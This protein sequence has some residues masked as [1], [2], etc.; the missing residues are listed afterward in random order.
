MRQTFINTGLLRIL[1]IGLVLV[2]LLLCSSLQV[3]AQCSNTC[4]P[5]LI[6]NPDFETTTVDCVGGSSGSEMFT[7]YSQVDGWFGTDQVFNDASHPDY[8]NSDCDGET[9]QNCGSGVGSVGFGTHAFIGEPR[10]YVQSQLVQ[11]LQAGVEYCFSTEAL[12]AAGTFL[13]ASDG[14]GIWFTDQMV[15][16]VM[17]NGGE[18]YIGPGSTINAQP[19]WELASG[20][21]ID[22]C[23]TRSG[24]FCALGGETW[25]VIGNFKNN[26]NT[27]T[28]GGGAFSSMIIDNLSLMEVC[29]P[30]P[31]ELTAS[32]TQLNCGS[33]ATLEAS[34]G[35]GNYIWIPNIG[36]G[37]GPHSVSPTDT[38]TYSVVSEVVGTCATIN[39]TVSVTIDVIG[40]CG[41]QVTV[42]GGSVCPGECLDLTTSIVDDLFPPYTYTWDNG[43]PNGPGPHEVCPSATTTYTVT[44]TDANGLAVTADATV[45]VGTLPVLST[46]TT[47]TTC[48][49]V[50]D[51]TAEVT[52][53]SGGTP[54]FSYSWNTVPVQ[55]TAVATGLPDG[56]WTVTV[57]DDNGCTATEDAVVT[58]PDP[59]TATLTNTP[60]NCGATDGTATAVALGGVGPYTYSWDTTPVQNTATA[61]SLGSGTYTVTIT[62]DNGCSIMESTNVSSTSP[63]T[64]TLTAVDV[65]CFGD[66]DGSATASMVGGTPPFTYSWNTVPV[67]N[68]ATATSLTA[69]SWTV[70][71]T[72]DNGCA[73]VMSVVVGSPDE[74]DL[75]VTETDGTCGLPNGSADVVVT[76]GNAP[77]FIEWNTVPVQN[78]N[79]ATGLADGNYTVTITDDNNCTSTA[80]AVI[81]NTDPLTATLT[82]TPADCGLMDGTATA[83][84]LGGTPPYSYAWDTTPVQ[85]TAT[86]TGLGA[87]TYTVTITDDAGCSI[88]ESTNVSS[89]SP[90][91]LTLTATDVSC[92]GAVDGTAT[93]TMV[94]GAAPFTY[95]WNTVPVQNAATA[96]GLDAGS[97]T[98]TVTDDNGCDQIMS[99]S[100]D[101]P[102]EILVVLSTTPGS[103]GQANGS[104]SVAISG[105]IGPYSVSWNTVPVQTGTS[106]IDLDD[107]TY[108]ASITDDNGCTTSAQAV[109]TVT[110]GP[111]ASF[112]GG[113]A[114]LGSVS[115]F[116]SNSPSA[117]Q[118]E[119]T[120]GDGST[121]AGPTVQHTY[122]TVGTFTVELTVT[123]D[124]GCT[125]VVTDDI[126]ISPVPVPDF[127]TTP[128]SGCAPLS[129]DFE[130]L[131][132]QPGTTCLWEFGDG[133]T[134]TDCASGSHTYTAP[135]CHDVTLTITATGCSASLTLPDVVCVTAPPIA[136]FQANPDP[137]STDHPLVTFTNTSVGASAYEWV[138]PI[139]LP[140]NSTLEDPVVDFSGNLP[141]IYEACL[142]ATN[143]SGCSDSICGYITIQEDF[144]VYVPNSFTPNDDGINDLFIPVL[145]GHSLERYSLSIF[146]RWG[147]HI[148]ETPIA[149]MGWDGRVNGNMVQDG[150]YIWKL[151][152]RPNSNLEI[153]EFTG[154]VT[155][156]R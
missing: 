89:T 8:W 110:P 88:D 146:N 1:W 44:V 148:Y 128:A 79:T 96:T 145:I 84:P 78:G 31:L 107:G 14:L 124:Q 26:A 80:N 64:L 149:S 119:W 51:G 76:G 94:G 57:T 45:V 86:A 52:V 129:V 50:D 152:V 150:V 38:T 16:I 126:T 65:S 77:Y 138:F 67:Q 4:G 140:D 125:D 49:D 18:Q 70:T 73:E 23:T 68:T 27:S 115:N 72:D 102:D 7:T 35:D 22:V 41:H 29:P 137:V 95:S 46:S 156:L 116:T 40:P 153:K 99:I 133:T 151:E 19:Y 118:W 97:W 3:K 55:N 62:D 54:P 147:E 60:A 2:A 120:M 32:A 25:I 63:G 117:T 59:V 13:Y 134:S 130:N 114:C 53:T 141:G 91:T 37:A 101:G 122:G 90:G 9:T 155:V 98:V 20:D 74:L 87:G 61:T 15:D 30:D 93:A 83:T 112:T 39:D 33:S 136:D 28:S 135:G 21:I 36:V 12:S 142:V 85:N 108:T 106:A 92:F 127:S 10:E 47:P 82:N 42:T 113:S 104:A 71:V 111:V 5:N 109:I 144:H 58:S 11:P 105:G 34:G 56:T 154:H 24:T 103:C 69:A 48:A 75:A 43:V 17:Q 121:Y 131:S 100:V 143:S 66:A 132:A 6:N 123:D 81:A 139:G